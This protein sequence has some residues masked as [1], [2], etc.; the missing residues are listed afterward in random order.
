MNN[1]FEEE[2]Y[3]DYEWVDQRLRE[4]YYGYYEDEEECENTLEQ[5]C[6]T[7][8]EEIYGDYEWI[9]QRLQDLY[10]EYIKDEEEDYDTNNDCF[11]TEAESQYK[12]E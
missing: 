2:E 8:Q 7:T 10:Y 9:D 3:G 12:K 11:N 6:E 5:I 1:S 4:I